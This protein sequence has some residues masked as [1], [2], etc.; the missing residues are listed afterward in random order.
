MLHLAWWIV[1]FICLIFGG[2]IGFSGPAE[3]RNV[4]VSGNSLLAWLML[5]ALAWLV[6][7]FP[8]G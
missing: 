1:W 7:G 2:Y 5:G 6:M 3:G 4:Y 8:K